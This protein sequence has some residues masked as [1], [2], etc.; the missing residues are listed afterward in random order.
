[1]GDLRHHEDEIRTKMSR[2]QV[3]LS[4][5]A[6]GRVGY[7]N[8]GILSS[9]VARRL[10]NPLAFWMSPGRSYPAS[11]SSLDNRYRGTMMPVAKESR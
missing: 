8:T 6:N 1:M 10:R 3:L 4:D 11:A 7:C 9:I 5:D 2:S